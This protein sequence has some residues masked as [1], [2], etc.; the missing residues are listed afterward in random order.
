M[1]RSTLVFVLLFLVAAGAYYYLKNRA[2]QTDTADIAVT[3]EPAT[4]TRYLFN[5][6]DGTANSIRVESNIGEVV[7]L[8]RDT[9]AE[10]AWVVKRPFEAAAD[11]GSSEAAA[12]QVTTISIV[13][14]V[15]NVEPKDVGLDDPQY[16]ITVEFS[17]GVE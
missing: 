11:Q 1:R 7:E 12:S 16:T 3:L 10:N 14:S 8:A 9:D 17:T 6:E 2:E 13:S 4:E 5:A 15:P